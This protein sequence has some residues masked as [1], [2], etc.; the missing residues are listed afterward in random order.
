[1]DNLFIVNDDTIREKE[2]AVG[3]L[4]KRLQDIDKKLRPMLDE[5]DEVKTNYGEDRWVQNPR[6]RNDYAARRRA[7][8]QEEKEIKEALDRIVSLSMRQVTLP[9]HLQGRS[10]TSRRPR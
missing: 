9:A 1:M 7:W 2:S 5:R 3:S 10:R 4:Q 6:P 8:E